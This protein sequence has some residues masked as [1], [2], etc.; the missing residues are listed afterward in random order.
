VRAHSK[1]VVDCASL[2]KKKAS[3]PQDKI[4]KPPSN[5]HTHHAT[6]T[7]TSKILQTTTMSDTEDEHCPYPLPTDGPRARMLYQ[8]FHA[9]EASVSDSYA[10][11]LEVGLRLEEMRGTDQ[12]WW[13]LPPQNRTTRS[14]YD[15]LLLRSQRLEEEHERLEA[16]MDEIEEAHPCELNA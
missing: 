7:H 9:V 16:R 4:F 3:S 13:T 11:M 6:S 10:E 5:P 8:Q 2:Y 12:P 14:C 1:V 15:C